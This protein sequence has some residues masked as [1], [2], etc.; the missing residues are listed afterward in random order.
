MNLL[1]SFNDFYDNLSS[2][3]LFFFW[4]IVFLFVFLIFLLIVLYFKNKKLIKLL[5]DN[6]DTTINTISEEAPIENKEVPISN[7]TFTVEDKIL[8][9]DTTSSTDVK[10]V[11]KDDGQMSMFGSAEPKT[12]KEVIKDEPKND[13]QMVNEIKPIVNETKVI[14]DNIQ[15]VNGPYKKNVLREMNTRGQTSPINIV[16]K[17]EASDT[18]FND[19]NDSLDTNGI[20][21]GEDGLSPLESME[22]VYD[23]NDSMRFASDV[24]SR[25]EKDVKPSNI[26]LTEYEKKQEEE[27]IISYDE[28]LKVKDKIYNITED[29]ETDEFIDELKN[30]RL[31]LQ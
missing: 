15:D 22:D 6:R 24:V 2:N 29:E 31:D 11:I 27:A 12:V 18:T 20:D 17:E 19:Y 10:E 23:V 9:N 4:I 25:M 5:K 13:V 1:N 8:E 21:L 30:F 16:K 3:G 7:A 28:L 14:K 26:E